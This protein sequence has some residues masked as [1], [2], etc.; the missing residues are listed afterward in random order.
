MTNETEEKSPGQ[1]AAESLKLLQ[2]REDL[3]KPSHY[4]M[5]RG[6]GWYPLNPVYDLAEHAVLISNVEGTTQ[7]GKIEYF[8]AKFTVPGA[9]GASSPFRQL[10]WEDERLVWC[11]EEGWLQL[12]EKQE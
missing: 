4:R 6:T 3:N 5:W 11:I 8:I 2:E 12:P 1:K 7:T 10:M 9:I